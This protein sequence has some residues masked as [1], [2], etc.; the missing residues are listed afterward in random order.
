MLGLQDNLALQKAAAETKVGAVKM[1][2]A[3]GAHSDLQDDQVIQKENKR[4]DYTFQHWIKTLRW[5]IVIFNMIRW[6]TKH[7]RLEVAF[8]SNLVAAGMTENQL[9]CGNLGIANFRELCEESVQWSMCLS[10]ICSRACIWWAHWAVIGSRTC[11]QWAH[12]AVIG[13]RGHIWWAFASW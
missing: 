13:S 5:G 8:A 4:K 9:F 3:A 12:W 7:L 2:S 6:F 10:M 11:I 1:L